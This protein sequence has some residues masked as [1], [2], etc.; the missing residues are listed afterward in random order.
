M[1]ARR[2]L[3]LDCCCRCCGLHLLGLLGHRLV[4]SALLHR[5]RACRACC[6]CC[7]ELVHDAGAGGDGARGAGA[8]A[9]GGALQDAV[10][11]GLRWARWVAREGG[12][13]VRAIEWLE[14]EERG[15][16]CSKGGKASKQADG[17]GEERQL[18]TGELPLSGLPRN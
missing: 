4:H 5:C 15:R 14:G 18:V 11:H 16:K 10:V 2:R 12:W 17:R 3:W 6:A 7:T 8:H 1:L 9:R 13:Q